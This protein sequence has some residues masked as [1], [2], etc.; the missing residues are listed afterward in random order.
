MNLAFVNQRHINGRTYTAYRDGDNPHI[1][2]IVCDGFQ[3][4][5]DLKRVWHT[6]ALV[7]ALFEWQS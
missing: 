7:E 4:I 2:C 1:Q 5:C 3:V 6:D